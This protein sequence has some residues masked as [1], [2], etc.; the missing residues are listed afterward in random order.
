MI[1]ISVVLT[2]TLS[3]PLGIYPVASMILNMYSKKNQYV[4]INSEDTNGYGQKRET[5]NDMSEI[6]DMDEYLIRV[7]VVVAATICAVALPCFQFIVSI[8][9][10][11]GVATICFIL[12]PLFHLLIDKKASKLSKAVDIVALILGVGTGVIS[13]AVT[14]SQT[15]QALA[16]C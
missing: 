6:A 14:V 15:Q 13:S 16:N 4:A 12:P 10:C 1:R 3:Q 8:L 11:F 5:N 9:G 7:G 2:V